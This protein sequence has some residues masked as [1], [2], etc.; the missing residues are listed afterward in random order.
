[1]SLRRISVCVSLFAV[2]CSGSTPPGGPAAT[3]T[4][5]PTPSGPSVDIEKVEEI[6]GWV[7]FKNVKASKVKVVVEGGN[8]KFTDGKGG[9]IV[10]KSDY[11]ADAAQDYAE[12]QLG[13]KLRVIAPP[14]T[15]GEMAFSQETLPARASTE[16][17]NK[18]TVCVPIWQG[19][20]PVACDGG[21]AVIGACCGGWTAANA[22][23]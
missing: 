17:A 7:R 21:G 1:M 5:S 2:A 11:R 8:V 20:G 16:C 19:C 22:P 15:L 6:E 4:A 14:E 23:K 18:S 9:F 13:A 12:I 3:P 10:P